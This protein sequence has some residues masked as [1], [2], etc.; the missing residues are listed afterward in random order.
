MP[1][2]GTSQ[3]TLDNS[4]ALAKAFGATLRKIDISAAVKQHL[5]DISH[6][7]SV[8]DTAY[9]NAQARERTQV[10]MDVANKVNGIVVGTGDLSE[11]A[12][13]WSTFNGDHMSMYNVNGGIP[14]TFVRA[15]IAHEAANSS[16]KIRKILNDVLDTPISPE[17][18]P[19]KDGEI[20]QVTEDIVGPYQLHDYFLF[21]LLRKGFSPSK[22]FELAKLSFN[23]IYDQQTIYKWL[24][25]F[26]RR[27]FSQQFKRSCQPDGVKVGTVDLSKNNFRMPSDACCD[28]W[29][30]NLRQVK[31]G[32]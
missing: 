31:T 28:S 15:L 19:L 11:G 18:L 17:L 5:Q 26:I 20:A 25:K 22:V 4:L 14:K 23:G 12:L 13:G 21:M 16:A 29:L 24:E 27:F 9:E 10:L 7:L 1:C 3:R 30:E 32:W 2:F 6:D 8:T